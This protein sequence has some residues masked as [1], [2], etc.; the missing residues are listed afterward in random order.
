[1]T[2]SVYKIENTEKFYEFLNKSK[3]NNILV[4]I[5]FG[6]IWCNPCKKIE[7]FYE[8]LASKYKES[9]FLSI[10]VDEIDKDIL[11]DYKV[12]SLPSFFVMRNGN[13]SELIKGSDPNKLEKMVEYFFN[14][15]C[16][17]KK[18]IYVEKNENCS[19]VILNEMTI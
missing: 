2:T 16:I 10:D 12:S 13:H 17:Y 7:P 6:A 19:Q 11:N 9:I 14:F 3:E 8:I 1:M 5:K 15:D 18:S 4:F